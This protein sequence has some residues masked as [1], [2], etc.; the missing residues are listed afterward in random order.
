[1]APRSEQTPGQG[2]GSPPPGRP[3]FEDRS[4]IKKLFQDKAGEDLAG[5]FRKLTVRP[6]TYVKPKRSAEERET[7]RAQSKAHQQMIKE[8]MKQ[9]EIEAVTEDK[10]DFK[11]AVEHERRSRSQKLQQ[12]AVRSNSKAV[13]DPVKYNEEP[14]ADRDNALAKMRDSA[15]GMLLPKNKPENAAEAMAPLYIILVKNG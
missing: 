9:Y 10:L 3:A 1:M 11:K 6:T 8:L 12:H 7:E 13:L 4:A 14:K 15:P 5:H 2:A